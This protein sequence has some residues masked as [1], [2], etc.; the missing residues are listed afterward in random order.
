ML[1]CNTRVI[2]ENIDSEVSNSAETVTNLLG[3]VLTGNFM[4]ENNNSVRYLTRKIVLKQYF[5]YTFQ[6]PE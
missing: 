4:I 2:H 6:I 1:A 3:S 5:H